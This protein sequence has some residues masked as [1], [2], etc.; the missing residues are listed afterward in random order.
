MNMN[1]LLRMARL[2]RNP[3]SPRRAALMAAVIVACF[4]LWGIEQF[5]GWPDWLTVNRRR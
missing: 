3:P 4:A 1:F 2:V 5:W